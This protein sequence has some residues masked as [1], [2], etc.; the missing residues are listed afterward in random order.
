MTVQF[1]I[2]FSA[3]LFEDENLV[4]FQMLK[5]GCR[6]LRAFHKRAAHF[7]FTFA[8][9]EHHIGEINLF[10]FFVSQAV[11]KNILAFSHLELLSS[12]VYYRV[13]LRIYYLLFTNYYFFAYWILPIA[14][15]FSWDANVKKKSNLANIY[16]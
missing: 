1:L 6:N 7:H 5:H 10:A 16:L 3:S 15:L 8:F 14:H 2:S 9:G 4:V 11:N 12:Y 13:Y